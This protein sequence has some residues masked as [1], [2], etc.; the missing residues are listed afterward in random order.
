MNHVLRAR[1]AELLLAAEA[2]GHR[3]RAH[4]RGAR[5]AHVDRRVADEGDLARRDAQ[6]LGQLTSPSR[7]AILTGKYSHINGVPV[8]NRFDGSQPTVAKYLQGAGYHT[9][10]FG[11]WGLGENDTTG[12]P[13]RKG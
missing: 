8:F 2:P 10:M 13:N 3:H 9:G 12:Q 5:G 11:K 1:R 7:A 6:L 4:A